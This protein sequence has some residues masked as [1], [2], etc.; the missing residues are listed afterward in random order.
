MTAQLK[1]DGLTARGPQHE[2]D[3]ARH[4]LLQHGVAALDD[5]QQHAHPRMRVVLRTL[6]CTLPRLGLTRK[7]H[8]ALLGARGL[9]N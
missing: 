1:V 3:D 4:A 8:D 6:A 2:L 5:L 7:H 9:N